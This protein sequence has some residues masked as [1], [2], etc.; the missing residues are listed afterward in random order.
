MPYSHTLP[1]LTSLTLALSLIGC[2]DDGGTGPEQ[3]ALVSGVYETTSRANGPPTCTPAAALEILDPAVGAL[4]TRERIQVEE[5][6]GEVTF[7]VEHMELLDGTP[8]N[9]DSAPPRVAPIDAEGNVS[10][11]IDLD[12]NYTLEGRAFFDHLTLSVEGK[13]DREA[14]PVTMTLSGTGTQVVRD[15]AADGP[16]FATCV[17]SQTTSAVRTDAW[18]AWGGTLVEDFGELAPHTADHGN[19]D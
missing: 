16:V 7:T 2:G 8:V 18:L 5:R 15:S 1:V 13:F 14:D 9:L 19:Q 3:P 10:W 11:E 4:E 6:A 12:G 17:Q